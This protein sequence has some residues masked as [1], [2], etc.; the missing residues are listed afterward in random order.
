MMGGRKNICKYTGV[1]RGRS[2]H[3][4]VGRYGRQPRS[5]S[6]RGCEGVVPHRQEPFPRDVDGRSGGSH[7]RPSWPG[8]AEAMGE[9][10]VAGDVLF[11]IEIVTKQTGLF[12]PYY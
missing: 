7:G 1:G 2:A 8:L 4:E 5:F 12:I 9:M 10:V 3:L 11:G 6:E